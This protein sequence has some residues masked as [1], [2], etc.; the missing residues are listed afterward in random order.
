MNLFEELVIDRGRLDQISHDLDNPELHETVERMSR[1]TSDLQ[2]IVLNMRMVPVET[3]FNR[4]PKMIRQLARDLHKKVDLEI[5]GAE[6]E[7]D[8]TVIDE[9]GDPLVHL[10]RNAMDHGVETPEVRK[11]NGK[12]EEGKIVLK[13]YHSGNHVFIEI[14]DDGAGINKEKVL[15]K[16]ISK[17]IVT[18]ETAASLY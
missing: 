12:S 18:R 17:G 1:V 16:A 7:L 2:T 11:A 3:V 8:R 5:V 15:E 14:T 10:L 13:A 9:I 4:F 6:T